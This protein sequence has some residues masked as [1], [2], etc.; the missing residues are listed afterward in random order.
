MLEKRCH[1]CNAQFTRRREYGKSGT[2]QGRKLRKQ[3]VFDDFIA[4]PI[5]YAMKNIPRI[6]KLALG[7]GSNGDC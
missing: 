7:G 1:L 2:M 5:T 3:N 4:A 6:I